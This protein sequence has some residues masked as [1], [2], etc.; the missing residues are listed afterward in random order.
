MSAGEPE[1]S[2]HCYRYALNPS[3][4]QREAILAAARVARR[5]WNALLACQRYA[6]HE[7]AHGRRGPIASGLTELLLAKNLTGAA[8]N[9]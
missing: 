5:Y 7:I 2:T 6:L 4:V 1:T 8:V 9:D 3:K